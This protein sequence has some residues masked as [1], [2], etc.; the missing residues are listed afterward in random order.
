MKFSRVLR[1]NVHW[2]E[3]VLQN[4]NAVEKAVTFHSCYSICTPA[5]LFRNECPVT[6]KDA[7]HSAES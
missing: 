1:E 7:F 3:R 5:T 6:Q 2:R 4:F